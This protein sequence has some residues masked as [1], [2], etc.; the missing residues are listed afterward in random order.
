MEDLHASAEYRAHLAGVF[1]AR[2]VATAIERA[3]DR[4][5]VGSP[6]S[7]RSS[8]A[9]AAGSARA[10]A[11]RFAEEGARVLAV[12][13]AEAG[14]N[15]TVAQIA[16]AGGQAEAVAADAADDATVAALVASA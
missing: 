15:E 16:R 1:I 13:L 4:A 10:S 11:L 14:V 3:K 2:A 12:D 5:W 8:P 6:E 7:A 9:R